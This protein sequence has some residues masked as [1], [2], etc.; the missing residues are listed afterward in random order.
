MKTVFINI[1]CCIGCRH[2]EIACMTEHS[3]GKD[4]SSVLNDKPVPLPRIKVGQGIDILAFPN[5]CRHCDP[6]PCMQACPTGAVFRD[7]DHGSVFVKEDK[8]ISC[9][10]CAMVCP[11][12]AIVFHNTPEVNNQISYKCDDCI[13][14]RREGKIPACVEACKTDA[15]L[16]G[17]INEI[18]SRSKQDVVMKIT[19]DLKGIK[20][21]Q[22]P[23]NILMFKGIMEKIA[24]LGPLPSSNQGGNR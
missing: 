22:E 23:E 1:S 9:G 17:E 12:S 3:V 11:F 19:S 16:F 21:F 4:L 2:C 13:D 14:R 15:L 24:S 7:L 10:M 5:R 18:I 8:C 20:S 6:A